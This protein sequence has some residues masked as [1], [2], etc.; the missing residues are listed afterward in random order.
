MST[1]PHLVDQDAEHLTDAPT[2]EIRAVHD[3]H[4]ESDAWGLGRVDDDAGARQFDVVDVE[5]VDPVDDGCVNAVD[6]ACF[7]PV[8]PVNRVELPG[9]VHGERSEPSRS[10]GAGGRLAS[11]PSAQLQGISGLAVLVEVHA[12][13]GVPS[14]SM[15]GQPDGACREARDRV[16]AALLSS[17]FSWPQ[18]RLTVNLAPATMR[19]AGAGL[20]L[21][22]AI[23][24]LVADGQLPAERVRGMAFLGELGL[25]GT[26]RRIP[27]LVSL[28]DD[29]LHDD[30]SIAVVVPSS[31]VREAL[32][33]GRGLLR[34]A[35]TLGGVVACIQ[36]LA[37]WPEPPED[38]IAE[39]A[40]P[41]PLDL[42]DVRGQPLARLGLEVAAAGGH[43]LLLAGPPGSGKSMLAARLV[44]V[45]PDL[46]HDEA[47]EVLRVHSAA[48]LVH[49]GG[50]LPSRPPFRSPHHTASAVALLGGGS[51][52]I[53][54][55]EVS[56]AHRG[57][58][59]LDEL[60]EFAP[61]VLDALRQPL[62]DGVVCVSRAVATVVLPALPLVVGATNPCPCGWWGVSV[63]EALGAPS[64]RCSDAS[65]AR[66]V[67]RLAG[68]L[69]D[70]FDIRVL[71]T[72]PDPDDLL[73][74]TPGESSAVVAARVADARCAA[75]ERG[76]ATNA[77]LRGDDLRRW[78]EL[79]APAARLVESRL[80][81]G[82]LTARGFDRI[83]RV[84][85]TLADLRGDDVDA[86]I[87]D[88]TVAM[89]MELRR[90]VLPDVVTGAAA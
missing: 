69:L 22:I 89:A 2:A 82:S 48:G 25:D 88:D 81:I 26:V 39:A 38:A 72:P 12:S 65:R 84:A 80:R 86:L 55:G 77:A 52:A 8:N 6:E 75:R 20:D 1:A 51:A 27:G 9:M 30:P 10:A 87:D 40:I 62:E 90:P 47:V 13:D 76:V 28:V 17:G 61:F 7:D 58:L 24:V 36:G 79:T 67:R 60:G 46:S 3:E 37:P 41:V 70:R 50:R 66:Y 73:S 49:A 32:L 71:V 31:G 14:F 11:V 35:I 16:R 33:L 43:H 15:V 54:P 64:C 53:R 78:T 45:L 29:L 34:C 59:F 42:A 5:V 57:V 74:A 44:S 83:R 21:A 4:G 18:R 19:K 56:C 85:R 68:P 63:G 23:A